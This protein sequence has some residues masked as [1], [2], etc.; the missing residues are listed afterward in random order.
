[1]NKS[2]IL[3]TLLGLS[4]SAFVE[5]QTPPPVQM[6]TPQL[7]DTLQWPKQ[8]KESLEKQLGIFQ[9][10]PIS[11][12]LHLQCNFDWDNKVQKKELNSD[13]R[14][15]FEGVAKELRPRVIAALQNDYDAAIKKGDFRAAMIALSVGNKLST[16]SITSNPAMMATLKAKAFSGATGPEAVWQVKNVVGTWLDGDFSKELPGMGRLTFSPKDGFRLLRV[17][18]TI[19]NISRDSDPAYVWYGLADP[20]GKYGWYRM[21]AFQ[22]DVR[23]PKRMVDDDFLFVITP[24]GDMI[25]SLFVISDDS[26]SPFGLASTISKDGRG[27][28]LFVGE[29]VTEGTEFSAGFVFQVPTGMEGLRLLMLGSPT[30]PVAI[31]K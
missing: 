29:Y 14:A 10:Q 19:K 21:E 25:P 22:N 18:A 16:N 4:I 24:G 1:M 2:L 11:A 15:W 7:P 13:H 8:F 5:A 31:K 3:V 9:Q 12:Y 26:S 23:E 28:A 6:A 17:E 20:M 27:S 30:V